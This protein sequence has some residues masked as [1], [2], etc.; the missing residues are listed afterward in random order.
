M[1]QTESSDQRFF[2]TSENAVKTQVWITVCVYVLVAIVRK[3][4]GFAI[5]ALYD[6]TDPKRHAVRETIVASTSEG[7]RK[8]GN[9]HRSRQATEFTVK[10]V[11]HY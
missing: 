8:P 3:Q 10:R 7:C 6:A 2:G 9:G 5:V 11:G 1:D 4:L